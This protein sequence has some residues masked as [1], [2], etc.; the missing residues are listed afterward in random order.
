M[1]LLVLRKGDNCHVGLVG[2]DCAHLLDQ[3]RLLLLPGDGE[4]HLH[5]AQQIGWQASSAMRP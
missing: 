3:R 4:K 5:Q 1:A 2:G